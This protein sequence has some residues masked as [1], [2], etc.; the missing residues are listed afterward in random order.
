MHQELGGASE[1]SVSTSAQSVG[2]ICAEHHRRSFRIV[3]DRHLEA[4]GLVCHLYLFVHVEC[5]PVL[6]ISSRFLVQERLRR[7][8]AEAEARIE[9]LA[10]LEQGPY[11]LNT[12]YLA[13]YKAKFLTHYRAGRR[14]E[15]HADLVDSLESHTTTP[16]SPRGAKH[17]K[18]M[19]V[20]EKND[21]INDILANLTTLGIPGVKPADLAKLIVQDEMEPALLIMAEVRAYFQGTFFQLSTILISS[22][23]SDDLV[24]YKR[25]VDNVPLAID[26]EL[27][28]GLE[29][30]LLQGLSKGLR[31]Y[32]PD[33]VV[34]CQELAKE[35]SQVADRREELGK[36]LERLL[37]A[38]QEL[39]SLM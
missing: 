27:V 37:N 29:K 38:S 23:L 35:S 20:Y 34:I 16:Q 24:A 15:Q 31:V 22:S 39:M 6:L 12:H 21:T 30:D 9:W 32:G 3:W 13:D 2:G 28:R 1:R 14:E 33:G 19:G 10:K 7:N 18:G 25:F 11:T 8:L 17:T 36:K 5:N 26:L 4:A